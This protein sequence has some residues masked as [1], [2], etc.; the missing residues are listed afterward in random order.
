M[1]LRRSKHVSAHALAS[2]VPANA[3]NLQLDDDR[4]TH[5]HLARLVE[6]GAPRMQLAIDRWKEQGD[7]FAGD[8]GVSDARAQ[9]VALHLTSTAARIGTVEFSSVREFSA[10][11]SAQDFSPL[12]GISS[13]VGSSAPIPAGSGSI[14]PICA[15]TMYSA[16][17]VVNPLDSKHHE[18]ERE[19]ACRPCCSLLCCAGMRG[20]LSVS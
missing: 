18:H 5:V 10:L 9:L 3:A 8:H 12:S 14:T 6:E 15:K 13:G 20:I 7:T 4:A 1:D 19:W 2:V 17:A 11:S 16:A